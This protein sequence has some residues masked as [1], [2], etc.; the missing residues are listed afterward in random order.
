MSILHCGEIR[1]FKGVTVDGQSI[2]TVG[3]VYKNP[4]VWSGK[5]VKDTNIETNSFVYDIVTLEGQLVR[6]NARDVSV[7]KDYKILKVQETI[8]KD[9]YN[10][11]R[12]AVEI[13]EAIQELEDRLNY[14]SE[15]INYCQYK[16]K[17]LVEKPPQKGDYSSGH[18]FSTV[19]GK[20]QK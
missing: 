8:L 13:K 11:L 20:S 9:T 4:N 14:S 6:V 5:F 17:S 19:R 2:N 7:L 12:S 15:K 10:W 18:P 3:I 1:K 16:L